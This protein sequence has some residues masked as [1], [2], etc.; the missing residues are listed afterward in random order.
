MFLFISLESTF[1]N[2]SERTEILYGSD[3]VMYTLSQFVSN[4]KTINSYND[5]RAPSLMMSIV[6]YQK[7]FDE[8]KK[9]D[10]KVRYITDITKD[11]L[12]YCK[13]INDFLY[14]DTALDGIETNFS[15]SDLEYIASPTPFQEIHSLEPIQ[16]IIYSNVKGIVQQQ[17][18]VFESFWNRSIPAENRIMELEEGVELGNTEVISN[19]IITK[20][21]FITLVKSSKEQV[22][23][24]I[25]SING[26]LREE[27]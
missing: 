3:K 10:I 25:P 9:R 1:T 20:D 13:N 18:Y 26:F 11:N 23:L 24:L 4:S 16:Q 15:V 2:N 21:L 19:P 17:K 5:H 14:G 8:L 12:A 22:L 27:T 6:D 7:L